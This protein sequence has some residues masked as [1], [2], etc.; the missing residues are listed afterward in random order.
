[1]LMSKDVCC[2]SFKG[3]LTYIEKKHGED[4]IK[5][6]T[7]GLINNENYLIQ[8]KKDPSK[9]TTVTLGHLYDP[10]YWISYEFSTMLFANVKKV[11][12]GVNPLFTAGE[13]AVR[14]NLSKN[15]VFAARILGPDMMARRIKKINE[16]G[17]KTKT[18]KIKEITNNSLT[19]ELHYNPGFKPNKDVCN[20]NLGIYSE[21]AK[22]STGSEVTC[23]E[24]TCVLDG[25]NK[26]T[27]VLR[28]KHVNR[29][30]Q[31]IKWLFRPFIYEFIEDYE[32]TFK[33]REELINHL[34]TSEKKYRFLVDNATDAI[35]IT[36]DDMFKFINPMASKITGYV[37]DEMLNKNFTNFIHPDD[38]DY[39]VSKYKTILSEKNIPQSFQFKIIKKDGRTSW[40]EMNSVKTLWQNRPA[41]LN[42]IRD[43]NIQKNLE[44][45]LIQSQKMEAA[46][47]LANG[48][49]HDFKNI[50]SIIAGNASLALDE[51]TENSETYYYLKKIT[52]NCNRA[53]DLV[54]HLLIF[55]R[56]KELK[57]TP[58]DISKEI[59][60]I[61]NLIS[62]SFPPNIEIIKDI[63]DN[64]GYI[65]ADVTQIHQVV[66][67][68]FKNASHA[69]SGKKGRIKISLENISIED[70]A[71]LK[72]KDITPGS[73]AKLS[74]S[75]SGSGIPPQIINKI[76]D[77]YFTTKDEGKGTGLGLAMAHGII[78]SHGGFISVDSE[79]GGGTTFMIYFPLL[80]EKSVRQNPDA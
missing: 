28:W 44:I 51:T 56:G 53:T 21:G 14:E 10:S 75:D 54:H 64:C 12:G 18:V 74:I 63:N 1:M 57:L 61:L 33:E 52:D 2:I 79:V 29:Y 5:K 39:V 30:K 41:T 59:K 20:W 43:I 11:E 36:Q 49:S 46:G 6:L 60:T 24:T 77:P 40:V 38:R 68:L 34:S 22:I 8:D 37:A 26:C 23:E 72:F 17:N 69:I 35:T 3:L 32:K 7:K 9:V 66:L 76:F 15:I 62:S 19:L 55:S 58:V 13:G 45:Q 78:K 80:D 71:D 65:K 16:L 70:T 4:G 67:N 25:D 47:T 73:Y 42:F 48:I 50:I 27:F 31:L